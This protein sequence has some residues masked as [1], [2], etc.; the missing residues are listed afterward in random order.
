MDRPDAGILGSGHRRASLRHIR[1]PDR[2]PVAGEHSTARRTGRADPISEHRNS[3]RRTA[4]RRA[5][6][7]AHSFGLPLANSVRPSPARAT[8]ADRGAWLPVLELTDLPELEDLLEPHCLVA[9]R[10]ARTEGNVRPTPVRPRPTARPS[11]ARARP[12]T[13]AR[14]CPSPTST[15]CPSSRSSSRPTSSSPSR[16]PRRAPPRRRPRRR[17]GSIRS[18]ANRSSTSRSSAGASPRP[19]CCARRRPANPRRRPHRRRRPRPSPGPSSAPSPPTGG[20]AA[21]GVTP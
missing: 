15:S 8:P 17:S 1:T 16:C 3:T 20:S 19:R 18:S 12:T 2:W 5:R 6:L 9:P 11:P 14:G 4:A 7:P 21:G 10:S 13:P